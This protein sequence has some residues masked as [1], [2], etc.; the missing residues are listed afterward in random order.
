MEWTD[1]E[2]DF[3][4]LDSDEAL[5]LL[6][7]LEEEEAADLPNGT[8]SFKVEKEKKETIITGNATLRKSLERGQWKR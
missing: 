8:D 4:E 1:E 3:C 5:E 2:D 6:D 7:G